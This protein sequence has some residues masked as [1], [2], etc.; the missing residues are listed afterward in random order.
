MSSHFHYIQAR[1]EL[2][3]ATILRSS[4]EWPNRLQETLWVSLTDNCDT[5]HGPR[6]SLRRH[7]PPIHK[8]CAIHRG[9][10]TIQ[11][12]TAWCKSSN[13]LNTRN[14]VGFCRISREFWKTHSTEQY[15]WGCMCPGMTNLNKVHYSADCRHIYWNILRVGWPC[16]QGVIVI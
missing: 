2:V 4:V 14:A 16:P 7:S 10:K 9:N 1:N 3:S 11:L 5:N 12:L 6:G 8:G 15:F 13:K